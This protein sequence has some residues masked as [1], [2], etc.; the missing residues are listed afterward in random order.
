MRHWK[1]WALLAVGLFA[2]GLQARSV[3]A[4]R[5][6]VYVGSRLLAVIEQPVTVTVSLASGASSPLE[7]QAA[8]SV[9]VNVATS[10]GGPLP[11]TVTL[12]W[13]TA[14]GT[15]TAASGDYTT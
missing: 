1:S 10:N 4:D 13:A 3:H 9:T 11:E 8:A 5:E 6:Y 12:A 7:S 2:A 15:A 14:D